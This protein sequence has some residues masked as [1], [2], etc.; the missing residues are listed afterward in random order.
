MLRSEIVSWALAEIAEDIVKKLNLNSNCNKHDF[1]LDP[2]NPSDYLVKFYRSCFSS[3]I[4]HCPSRVKATEYGSNCGLQ[5][6]ISSICRRTWLGCWI[7]PSIFFQP[8]IYLKSKPYARFV[9]DD[10]LFIMIT[11][12]SHPTTTLG[13][14]TS[15]SGLERSTSGAP[16]KELH[17]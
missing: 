6:S 2:Y 3:G 8:W 4:C 5:I 16:L 9:E 12:I 1:S 7:C 11:S 17:S 14:S 15:G 10:S 13:T